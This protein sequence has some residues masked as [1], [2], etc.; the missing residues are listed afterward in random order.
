[1]E[2]WDGWELGRAIVAFSALLYAGIW[3][4]LTLMHWAAGF[5]RWEMLPPVF[6]TPVIVLCALLGVAMRDGVLGWIAV[7]ALAV[8]AI[9]GLAGLFFHLRGAMYQVGGLT[10]RN[11]MAGPPPV[12]PVAYSLAGVLGLLG[13]LWDA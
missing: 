9:E 1:M 13:M 7:A 2:P 12:L 5:R 4:Q 11:L 8:G 10:L 6:V 3:V